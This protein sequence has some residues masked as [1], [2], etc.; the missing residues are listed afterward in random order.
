MKKIFFFIITIT[1]FKTLN[2]QSLLSWSVKPDSNYV[3]SAS[4]TMPS[5]GGSIPV[6]GAGRRMIWYADKAA[7]RAGYVDGSQWNSESIGLY[8]VALGRNTVANGLN[9]VAL[10]S[11]STAGENSI[12]IGNTAT[13][14]NY[15]IAL[16][17][18]SFASGSHSFA[19]GS[20]VSA[21]GDYS[22]ALGYRVNTNNKKGSFIIGDAS[23][24]LLNDKGNDADN[25]MMMRFANGYK[26]FTAETVIP[27]AISPNGTV[28]IDQSNQNNGAINTAGLV[29]GNASGEGIA[30][31]RT[32]GGNQYGLD[33]YSNFASRLSITNGG[34]IGIGTQ[35]PAAKF[36]LSTTGEDLAG[37]ACSKVFKTYSGVLASNAGAELKL[38]SFGFKSGNWSSLGITAYRFNGADGWQNAAILFGYDVD[39]TPGAGSYFSLAGN[40]NFGVGTAAPSS[41]LHVAGN[42]LASGSITPSDIRYKKEITPVKNAMK[43]IMDISGY[44]YSFRTKEFPDMNFE[45][46]E[47]I[48][49]LAQ[50]VEKVFPEVVS[51][52]PNGYKAVDYPKL[53][54]LLIQG[55]KEQQQQIDDLKKMVALLLQK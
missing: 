36:S 23:N 1:I 43:K 16:G 31:R 4:S 39:N 8:S 44:Y 27:F 35:A 22:S 26:F 34:N 12:A 49:V 11:S 24:S 52:L 50:D 29:F 55:M 40:G 28:V 10:G 45:T 6:S 48:G 17:S 9:A 30:S 7:F 54:P 38:A 25:Q 21:N 15:S 33:F 13:A 46:K 20:N 5:S 51:T 2:A 42:I 14:N 3:F 37:T 47:Q 32:G 19:A 41:K 53:I 18:P